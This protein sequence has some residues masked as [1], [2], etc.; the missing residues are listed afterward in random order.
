MIILTVMF[1]SQFNCRLCKPYEQQVCL[2]FSI[3][4]IISVTNHKL[5][6]YAIS[7][8]RNLWHF[9]SSNKKLLISTVRLKKVTFLLGSVRIAPKT[10]SNFYL[11]L[12]KTSYTFLDNRLIAQLP[13]N[14]FS[15][16]LFPHFIKQ[17][18]F[19]Q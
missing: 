10:V 9:I 17:N 2:L 5:A 19:W 8:V 11:F 7:F 16:N 4:P 3:L 15:S 13:N 18:Y 6:Y 1:T 14:F 12:P